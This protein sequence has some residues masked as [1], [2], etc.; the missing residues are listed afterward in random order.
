MTSDKRGNDGDRRLEAKKK[1]KESGAQRLKH[2]LVLWIPRVL[3]KL[4]KKKNLKIQGHGLMR[5]C[6]GFSLSRRAV[7]P[8]APLAFGSAGET[9]GAEGSLSLQRK[10]QQTSR[11]STKFVRVSSSDPMSCQF[12]PLSY[13]V[14]STFP[15]AP[16]WPAP[17][18]LPLGVQ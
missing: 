9:E 14:T 18:R 17:L 6:F 8:C 7:E 2:A 10:P 15:K 12:S 4:K 11:G 13:H 3:W 5:R 1:K 16:T